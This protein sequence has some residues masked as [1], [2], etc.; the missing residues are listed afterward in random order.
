MSRRRK[1][2][3]ACSFPGYPRYATRALTATE[4]EFACLGRKEFLISSVLDSILQSTALPKD[5]SE[6]GVP[7][8]IASFLCKDWMVACNET[9]SMMNKNQSELKESWIKVKNICNAVSQVIDVKATPA[10]PQRLIIPMLVCPGYFFV[11]CF[12]FCVLH[13]NFFLTYHSTTQPSN[14]V[15]IIRR[16]QHDMQYVIL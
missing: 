15:F 16:N 2:L 10:L 7:P 5:V 9:A 14:L 8:I 3:R 4:E 1:P 11:A 12:D 13:P 6:G